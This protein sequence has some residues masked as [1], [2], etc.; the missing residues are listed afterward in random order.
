M[1]DIGSVTKQLIQI[2][3]QNYNKQINQDYNQDYNQDNSKEDAMINTNF[4]DIS[5]IQIPYII[6]EQINYSVNYSTEEVNSEVNS[7]EEN[8]CSYVL[9]FI[10]ILLS[11][12][13]IG[14]NLGTQKVIENESMNGISMGLLIGLII[15]NLLW[16]SIKN[17]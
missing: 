15:V 4:G 2:Q 11:L 9:Y 14:Y 1:E 3:N 8:F 7:E 12:G 10:I 17:N 5:D 6:P 13:F 16:S